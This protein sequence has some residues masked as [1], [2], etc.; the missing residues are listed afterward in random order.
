M[1]KRLAFMIML[2]ALV[3]ALG[4]ASTMYTVTTNTGKTYTAVDKPEFKKDSKT[5][6]FVDADGNTVT[7]NQSEITEIKSHTK[8]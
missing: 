2:A 1:K 7:L 6:S 3:L 5:Y 4:C 8:K